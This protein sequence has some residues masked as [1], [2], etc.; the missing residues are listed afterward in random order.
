[1]GEIQKYFRM[2]EMH[3]LVDLELFTEH[4]NLY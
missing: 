2:A 4:A 3:L 1:M